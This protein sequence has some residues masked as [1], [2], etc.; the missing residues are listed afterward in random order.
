[1][2]IKIIVALVGIAGVEAGA[3]FNIC[4]VCQGEKNRKT[5]DIR[6]GAYLDLSE[7]SL[8]NFIFF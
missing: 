1:V 7:Y 8:V 4:S 5:I 3:F 2:G 6:A